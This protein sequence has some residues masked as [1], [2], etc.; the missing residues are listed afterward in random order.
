VSEVSQESLDEK[1]IREQQVAL[2]SEANQLLYGVWCRTK[3]VILP[4]YV[5]D[6]REA[7]ERLL[8][9]LK[10]VRILKGKQ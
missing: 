8:E 1:K 5:D 10:L 7:N 2:I 4:G 6:L 9:A 3:N